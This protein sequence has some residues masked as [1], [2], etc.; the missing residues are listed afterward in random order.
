MTNHHHP[1][2][3]ETDYQEALTRI[4]KLCDTVQPGTPEGDE[5]EVLLLLI[6]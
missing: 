3:T 4:D 5:T 1:I 2:R 6:K